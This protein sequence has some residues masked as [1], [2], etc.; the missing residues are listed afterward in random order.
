MAEDPISEA[1]VPE[2]PIVSAESAEYVSANLQ[3]GENSN[4]VAPNA[5]EPV[6]HTCKLSGIEKND[7]NGHTVEV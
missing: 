3:R 6:A 5:S 2:Q 4:T 7:G 1:A